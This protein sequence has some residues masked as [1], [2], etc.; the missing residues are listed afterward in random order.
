MVSSRAK[1]H[2][3]SVSQV[4]DSAYVVMKPAEFNWEEEEEEICQTCGAAADETA[5]ECDNCL[6]GFH[7]KCLSPPLESIP[8]VR[9]QCPCVCLHGI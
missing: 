5:L 2:H 3:L 4:G 8:K 7:L 1:I 6:L 9:R